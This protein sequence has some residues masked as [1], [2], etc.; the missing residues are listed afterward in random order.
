MKSLQVIL[1][2]YIKAPH[3]VFRNISWHRPKTVSDHRMIF[4]LGAPRSGT[5]LMERILHAHS[6]L[7]S[8]QKETGLLS[9]RNIFSR[10][11]FGLSTEDNKR[12]FSE[13]CDVIDFLTRA[14]ILLESRNEGRILIEKTPQHV[15]RLGFLVKH[16]PNARFIHVVRDGRDGYCSALKHPN[17]RLNSSAAYARYWKRCTEAGLSVRTNPIVHTVRYEDFTSNPAEHLE[18]LMAFLGLE[19]EPAQFEATQVKADARASFQRHQRLAQPISNATVGRWR[20]EMSGSE[21]QKFQA[22]AGEELKA[23][24][25]EL[26]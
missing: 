7:F 21:V 9:P 8:A 13:S 16:F 25:Y 12:L 24:G 15:L 2:S 5:T 6:R 11:H 1:G 22:V 26:A 10:D 17:V 4:V 3:Q 20:K 14:A 19:L 23:F 18:K